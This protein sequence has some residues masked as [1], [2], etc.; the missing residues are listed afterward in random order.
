[1]YKRIVLALTAACLGASAA[2][3]APSATALEGGREVS[4][5]ELEA[6]LVI[7]MIHGGGLC[8]GV[9]IDPHWV[10]TALHCKNGNGE[11][12]LQTGVNYKYDLPLRG[13]WHSDA[14]SGD[15]SLIYIPQDLGLPNYAEISKTL[16][17]AGDRGTNYGWGIGTSAVLKFSYQRFKGTYTTSGYNQGKMFV[18]ENE[19]GA[20]NRT[21]DSGGPVFFN[22]QVAGITSSVGGSNA[23]NYSSVPEVYDWIVQTVNSKPDN[24]TTRFMPE[25]EESVVAKFNARLAAAQQLAEIEREMYKKDLKTA[26]ET[27]LRAQRT[28]LESLGALQEAEEAQREAEAAKTQ[29]EAQAATAQARV[30][31]LTVQNVEAQRQLA[32]AVEEKTQAIARA[33]KA[34]RELALANANPDQ[35]QQI[36]AQAEKEKQDAI[37][38]AD[39]ADRRAQAAEAQQREAEAQRDAAVDKAEKAEQK[40]AA[41]LLQQQE[42]VRARAEAETAKAEAQA[43]A[44][45]A[46]QRAQQAEAAAQRRIEEA[47]NALREA[48]NLARE[49][50]EAKNAAQ[51]DLA[52]ERELTKRLEQLNQAAE[53]K[54]TELEKQIA[55]LKAELAAAKADKQQPEQPNPGSAG[56]STPAWWVTVIGIVAALFSGGIIGWLLNTWRSN[57][58]H[59]GR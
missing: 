54:N 58:A 32:E 30:D 20:K 23:T 15:I 39:A 34:E 51:R 1:M 6:N 27:S 35:A 9:A 18:T 38:N 3:V 14:P 4:A 5:N 40:A 31:E 13:Q 49:M 57:M 53:A 45:Q 25:I 7:R 42:A 17:Q 43:Q 41:A 50:E 26:K 46:Q 12:H 11:V 36:L 56:S 21:G 2:L 44:A 24:R 16:P 8:T 29:A 47:E 28:L 19:D 22:G 55:Q 33:E 48:R 52:A 10:L 59:F 37:H